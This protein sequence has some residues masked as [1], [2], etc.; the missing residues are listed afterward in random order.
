[1]IEIQ[2]HTTC[3]VDFKTSEIKDTA[4]NLFNLFSNPDNTEGNYCFQTMMYLWLYMRNHPDISNHSLLTGII[5]FRRFSE[6]YKN[7]IY[8]ES[9]NKKEPLELSKIDAF[10]EFL[11]KLISRIFDTSES[12]RQS[13]DIKACEYC[14]YKIICNK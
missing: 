7:V 3:I 9:R 8:S 10:E 5:S 12:F 2:D 13:E 1:M 6:G 4:L 14:S 11:N